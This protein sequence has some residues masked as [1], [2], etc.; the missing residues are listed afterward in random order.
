V[1][2]FDGYDQPITGVAE[3]LGVSVNTVKS[4]LAKARITLR[5]EIEHCHVE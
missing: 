5:A 3:T 4:S 2:L 1:T